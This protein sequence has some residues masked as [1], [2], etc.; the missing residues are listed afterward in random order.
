MKNNNDLLIAVIAI[1]IGF[2]IIALANLL[3]YIFG[4]IVLYLVF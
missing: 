3:P 4:A 2:C 1:L